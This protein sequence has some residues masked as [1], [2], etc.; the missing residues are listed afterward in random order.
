MKRRTNMKRQPCLKALAVLGLVGASLTAAADDLTVKSGETFGFDLSQSALQVYNQAGSTVTVEDGATVEVTNGTFVCNF[1]LKGEG[2]IL[3]TVHWNFK[4]VFT[5]KISG[6]GMIQGNSQHNHVTWSQEPLISFAGDLSE[7]TGRLE[8]DDMP[9]S[10]ADSPTRQISLAH[11]AGF[12]QSDD[13]SKGAGLVLGA[14]QTVTAQ[15]FEGLSDIRYHIS[16]RGDIWVKGADATSRLVLMNAANRVQIVAVGPIA[17][18]TAGTAVLDFLTVTN[19][20]VVSLMGGDFVCV[21]GADGRV[22]VAG[23]INHIYA[24]SPTAKIKV[25][26][27]GTLEFGNAAALSAVTGADTLGLWLDATVSESL[28]QYDVGGVYPAVFTNDSIVIRRWNDRRAEQT[29]VYGLN[30]TG[31]GKTFCYPYVLSNACNGAS[32]VSF[33]KFKGPIDAKW[34]VIDSSGNIPSWAEGYSYEECRRM[35]F[36]QAI[37]VKWSAMV[38]SSALEGGHMLLGGYC[39][40]KNPDV[41]EGETFEPGNTSWNTPKVE[42]G[43]APDYYFG[44]DWGGNR[45]LNQGAVPVWLDGVKLANAGDVKEATLSG[46]YQILTIDSRQA[47]GSGTDVRALGTK[48]DD[49]YNCGGQIYGEIL[50]FTNDVTAAQRRAVESYLAAKWRVPGYDV[51]VGNLSVEAG[52]QFQTPSALLPHGL[53]LSRTLSFTLRDGQVI[54]P[55]ALEGSEVDASLGGTVTVDFGTQKPKAG[56]YRLIGAKRV[57][58]LDPAAWTLQTVPADLVRREARLVWER[59]DAGECTGLFLDVH[60]EGCLMLIR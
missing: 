21:G 19:Q 13:K 16:R 20:A 35:P 59:N 25:L 5:G 18:Q 48:T 9:V 22:E 50:L 7:F 24:P 37:P 32:A 31:E 56:R 49:G 55:V 43:K 42:G 3:R 10:F 12:Q 1:D 15:N 23:G 47:D 8:L 29:A 60:A 45:V 2:S 52:G 14:G 36:N 26:S 4:K 34:A 41:R 51:A 38:Y 28:K 27:G 17:L 46:G 11:L 40:Q 58:R 33:G 6:K 57:N 44:R 30:P 39:L 53:G 54:D